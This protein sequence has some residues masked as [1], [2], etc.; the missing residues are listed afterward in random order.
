MRLASGSMI[1]EKAPILFKLDSTQKVN[2]E[3]LLHHQ[4]DVDIRAYINQ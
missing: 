4:G 3:N 1:L 2:I